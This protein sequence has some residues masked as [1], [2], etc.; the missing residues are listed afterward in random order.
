MTAGER[1]R[2]LAGAGGSAAALLLLIGAGATAGEAL[3]DYSGLASATAAGHLLA[4]VVPAQAP[5]S[6]GGNPLPRRHGVFR[7]LRGNDTDDDV[8]LLLL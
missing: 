6:E 7:S 3:R 5:T 8:L 2:A 4:E 1:L